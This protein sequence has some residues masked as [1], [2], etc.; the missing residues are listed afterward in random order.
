[1]A[2]RDGGHETHRLHKR[3]S[4]AGSGG[5]VRGEHYVISG[6]KSM[7]VG[8]VGLMALGA[9]TTI[10]QETRIS[11]PLAAS[12]YN[13]IASR[14]MAR[15]TFVSLQTMSDGA[16]TLRVRMDRYDGGYDPRTGIAIEH[17]LPFDQRYVGDYLPMI[18]KY[19]DWE[20]LASA[21][22]DQI[23]RDIGVAQTWGNATAGSLKF[24]LF[25]GNATSHNLVIDY[26]IA[27][28]CANRPL[29]FSKS[30]AIELRRLLVELGAGRLTQ[31]PVGDIYK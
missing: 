21:R 19:L 10:A 28:G 6:M 5:R 17:S 11:T 18:D 3:V 9:C 31:T 2:G 16:I 13:D 15:P 24:G 30:S 22:G 23:E 14:Y 27:T 7:L 29:L 8:A 12:D 20:K 4:Q 26:C 25:S 1:M